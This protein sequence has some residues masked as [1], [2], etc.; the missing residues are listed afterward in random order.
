MKNQSCSAVCPTSSKKERHM[1]PAT[2]QP[3]QVGT[4]TRMDFDTVVRNFAPS[5]FAAVMGTGVMAINSFNYGQRFPVLQDIGVAVHWF[6]VVLFVALLVPWTLRWLKY[7]AEAMAALR[8]PIMTQFYPTISIALLVLALQ[9]LVFG[10]H[11]EIAAVLWCVGTF[12]TVAFS[13]VVPLITFQNDKVTIDHV[14]PGMFIPPVG[15][16][17]I[18]LAGS[19]LAQH[20]DGTLKELILL[21]S[22]ISLGS[23]FF[24]YLALL[25]LTMSRF[26]VGNPL[27]AQLLPMV[28]INLGPIGVVP[29]SLAG[30]VG[31]SPFL[32][33]KEPFFGLALLIWGFGA[34]WLTMSIIL[35]LGYRR[36]GELPFSLAWW[37]FT[38]PL[39]A[40]AA[41]GHYLGT[42]FHLN[43]VWLVGL[44]AY[45]LL[46]F[47]W[48]AAFLNTLG[49]VLRGTLFAPPAQ[50][51]KAVPQKSYP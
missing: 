7:R 21:V 43:T 38:F 19:V 2:T 27:P 20:A 26:I 48:G 4:G 42:L 25:A 16:V 5:W 6:N 11:I 10:K 22:Y 50:M 36:R 32:V 37:A 9:F 44:A 49:G 51:P 3:T 33:V 30:L 40:Y 46:V 34:W 28:W 13:I 15:L 24:L 41:A 18:P 39:G 29:I 45:V 17:L 1:S 31:A 14:T 47:L 35:T 8:H 23:G 12:L